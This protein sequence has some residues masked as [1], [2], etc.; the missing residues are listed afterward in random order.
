MAFIAFFKNNNNKN[1][2]REKKTHVDSNTAFHIF[3][4][5]KPV[6]QEDQFPAFSC[7]I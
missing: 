7:V 1:R 5:E 4:C 2:K 6:Y 3:T